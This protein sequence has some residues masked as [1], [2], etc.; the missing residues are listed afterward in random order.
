[1][2]I[3]NN[4]ITRRWN[5]FIR[6]K[7]ILPRIKKDSIPKDITLFSNNC[8]GGV[9]QHELGMRFNSPTVNLSFYSLD[10]FDFA[11]HIEYYLSI[12]LVEADNPKYL[13]AEYDKIKYPIMKLSGNGEYPDLELHFLHYHSVHEAI[14]TWNRRK[15]R[16]NWDNIYLLWT[17]SFGN[18]SQE[19]YKRFEK[20]PVENKIAFVNHKVDEKEFPHLFYIK[21]FE[22]QDSIQQVLDYSDLFGHRYYDQFDFLAWFQ[23]NNEK[24]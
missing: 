6:E 17:F 18:Y 5:K 22:K 16:I 12:P 21:G 24:K 19:L 10:F 3:N 23:N 9:I 8:L 20:I 13:P 2:N 7:F 14:E 4:K 11:E 15:A 1:M